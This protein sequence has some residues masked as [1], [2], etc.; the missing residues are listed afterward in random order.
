M[1]LAHLCECR[2]IH[3]S[4]HMYLCDS[5]HEFKGMYDQPA[6]LCDATED[7]W[8][9]FCFFESSWAR[10]GTVIH[11]REFGDTLG[12]ARDRTWWRMTAESL[13]K[14]AWRRR[15]TP[16]YWV[17][18]GAAEKICSQWQSLVT[19]LSDQAWSRSGRCEFT[20]LP[21]FHCL[22]AFL[23]TTAWVTILGVEKDLGTTG[24]H[25]WRK[26]RAHLKSCRKGI[27]PPDH[28]SGACRNSS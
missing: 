17:V 22:E 11:S 6:F 2:N 19:W 13:I 8:D 7:V 4:A 27:Y 26:R 20:G 24:C 18:E 15:H 9:K 16:V 25:T 23:S 1:F 12:K 5:P 21:C 14:A 3:I 10:W 28:T